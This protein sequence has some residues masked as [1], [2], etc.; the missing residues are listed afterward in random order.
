MENIQQTTSISGFYAIVLWR[1]H[2]KAEEATVLLPSSHYF[3]FLDPRDM[4][5]DIVTADDLGK[6][7]SKRAEK[8]LQLRGPA[9]VY[10]RNPTLEDPEDLD[11]GVNGRLNPECKALKG[12]DKLGEDVEEFFVLVTAMPPVQQQVVPMQFATAAA[13]PFVQGKS[14]CSGAVFAVLMVNTTTNCKWNRSCF[15]RAVSESKWLVDK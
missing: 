6:A 8:K 4:E 2:E 12:R 1:D 13:P 9:L 10:A 5:L 15:N 7:T 14:I 11:P 3:T